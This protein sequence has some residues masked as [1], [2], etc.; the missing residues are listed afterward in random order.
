MPPGW[1]AVPHWAGTDPSRVPHDEDRGASALLDLQLLLGYQWAADLESAVGSKALATE[2][3]AAAAVLAKTIRALYWDAGRGLFADTAEK[4]AFSQ[5]ANI[6]AVLARVTEGDAAGKLIDRVL[7]DASLSQVSIYF[8]H[9]LAQAMNQVG[10]GDRYAASLG[11]WRGMLARGLTTWSE[12]ADPTRSDCHAWG[13]SPNFEL[14]RTVLGIDSAAPGFRR[15]LVRP[16]LGDLTRASGSIP[17]PRGAIEVKVDRVGPTLRAEIT[18][19][20]GVP[21]DLVW[22]GARKTLVPGPNRVSVTTR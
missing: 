3:R 13:A 15:V 6:L 2:H 5:H 7:T 1:S 12:T 4:K 22:G 17:H 8:R 11:E 9:Y 21:G 16:F 14:Y 20:A 18:L 10:L 19:P